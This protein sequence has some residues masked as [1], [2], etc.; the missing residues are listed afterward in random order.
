MGKMVYKVEPGDQ[1]EHFYDG[2]WFHGKMHSP[3]LYQFRSGDTYVGDFYNNKRHGKGKMVYKAQPGYL[4]QSYYE[5][6]WRHSKKHG[7]EKRQK[8]NGDLYKG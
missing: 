6:E 1:T 7:E 3:G 8:G 4:C 2:E 5:G